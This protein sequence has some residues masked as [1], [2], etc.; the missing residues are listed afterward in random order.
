MTQRERGFSLLEALMVTAIILIGASVAV[1]QLRSSMKV[2]AADNA[3]NLVS[4]Q[5]RY[6]R[7]IAVDQ[8]RNVLVEFVGESEIR[9]TRVDGA[10]ETTVMSDVKLP[11]GF[12]FSMP[13]DVPDTPD[14]YGNATPV[15]FNLATSGTILADGVFVSEGGIVTNGSIFTMGGGT[16]TARAITVTGASG[17]TRVYFLRGSSW[18]ERN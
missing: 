17:R 4:S 2:L 15:Y 6:A 10:G 11:P 3:I 13:E 14:G 5:I 8:R 1:I 12:S 7:Q 9:I 16:G 18:A